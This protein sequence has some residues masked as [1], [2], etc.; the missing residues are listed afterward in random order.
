MEV[1]STRCNLVA[2]YLSDDLENIQVR[3]HSFAYP[4]HLTH[5]Q[6]WIR[7]LLALLN[8]ECLANALIAM[9]Q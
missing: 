8:G 9:N 4:V 1:V 2:E 7:S 6:E 3:R 5:C